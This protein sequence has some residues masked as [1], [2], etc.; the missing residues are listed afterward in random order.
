MAVAEKLRRLGE[1]A[2][3]TQEQM[4]DQ[5]GINLWMTCSYE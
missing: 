1:A 2:G 3:L 4:A 5:G